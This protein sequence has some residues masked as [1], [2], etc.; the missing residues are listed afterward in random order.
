MTLLREVLTAAAFVMVINY[1]F[2]NIYVRCPEGDHFI[3]TSSKRSHN[4]DWT[5]SRLQAAHCVPG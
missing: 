3:V 4:T 1:L 5:R 2:M